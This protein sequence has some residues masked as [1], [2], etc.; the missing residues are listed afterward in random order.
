[1]NEPETILIEPKPMGI[2][3]DVAVRDA[4]QR[5]AIREEDARSEAFLRSLLERQPG[6]HVVRTI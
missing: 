1:M 6:K 5:E 3:I 2:P 4:M